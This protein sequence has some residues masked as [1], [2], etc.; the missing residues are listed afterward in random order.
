MLFQP[1]RLVYEVIGCAIAVHKE[2]GPGLLE[3]AYDPCVV[4]ELRERGLRFERQV[5]VPLTYRSTHVECSYRVDFV[6]EGQLVVELKSIE[7]FIPLH[8]A[9]LI[10]YL[11]LLGLQQGLLINFN[12]SRLVDGVKSVLLT[13]GQGRHARVEEVTMPEEDLPDPGL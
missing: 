12:V 13:P 1:S 6:I 8:T 3:S 7:R 9:Q 2:I 10:T 4:M 5:P 11:K